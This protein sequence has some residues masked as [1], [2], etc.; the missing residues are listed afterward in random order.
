DFSTHDLFELNEQQRFVVLGKRLDELDTTALDVFRRKINWKLI[1]KPQG[2]WGTL[3]WADNKPFSL[4]GSLTFSTEGNLRSHGATADA[5]E[6]V[7][8]FFVLD[9]NDPIRVKE[10]FI[11]LS[12]V[13]FGFDRNEFSLDDLP[14]LRL[15]LFV[16]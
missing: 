16:E 15:T 2:V 8:A 7:R 11:N 5:V 14:I 9:D 13:D 6:D 4:N 12:T 10:R 1:S 3:G